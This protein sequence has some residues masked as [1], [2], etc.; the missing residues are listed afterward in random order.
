MDIMKVPTVH[1]NLVA[2]GELGK[3]FGTT[4]PPECHLWAGEQAY[5]PHIHAIKVLDIFS[6]SVFTIR[7]TMIERRGKCLQLSLSDGWKTLYS[8]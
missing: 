3:I 7:P 8:D 5:L 2:D 6:C 1:R 4:A